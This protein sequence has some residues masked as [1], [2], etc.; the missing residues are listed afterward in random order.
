M[1]S[2]QN[3][4]VLPLGVVKK[5]KQSAFIANIFSVAK[6][7][8]LHVFWREEDKKHQLLRMPWR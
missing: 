6:E 5:M 7:F 2:S 8:N 4:I 1:N 3:K